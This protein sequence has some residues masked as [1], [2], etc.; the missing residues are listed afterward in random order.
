MA[1][2]TLQVAGALKCHVKHAL[3]TRFYELKC[4]RAPHSTLTLNKWKTI[5]TISYSWNRTAVPVWKT[6]FR[7]GKPS[8]LSHNYQQR[9]KK[10]NIFCSV[11]KFYFMQIAKIQ[12]DSEIY[13]NFR[14]YYWWHLGDLLSPMKSLLSP[15]ID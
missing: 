1:L 7:T 4:A 3:S 15:N 9:K 12:I 11:R 5:K 6:S 10:Q 2:S 14:R 8:I 13:L